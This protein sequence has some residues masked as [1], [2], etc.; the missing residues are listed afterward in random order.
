M[1]IFPKGYEVPK[2]PSKYMKFDFGQNMFRALSD[3]IVGFEWWMDVPKDESHPSGRMPVRAKLFEDI[4]E[5]R[6]YCADSSKRAKAFMAFVVFNYSDNML[7]ILQLTQKSIMRD[8]QMLDEDPKWGDLRKYDVS[9]TKIKTGSGQTDV[10]YSVRPNPM[11]E[12]DP[13]I[14]KL[15][16]ETY[17]NLDALWTGADPFVRDTITDKDIE[18]FEKSLK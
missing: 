11:A 17:V 7:Q 14:L 16:K 4:P 5:D 8:L 10:E 18:D 12:T 6:K 15:Y 1:S 13:E 3:A 9:I 2:S